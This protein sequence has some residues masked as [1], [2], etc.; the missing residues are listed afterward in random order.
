M[1]LVCCGEGRGDKSNRAERLLTSTSP[2]LREHADNPVDWYE[3]GPEALEKAKSENKPLIISIG[4]ASCHWCHVMEKESF[5]DTAVARLMNENFV[6]VKIDREQRPD[7]DQIYIHAAQLITGSAG[8]PLNAFA[9]PDGKPFYAGTYF[10]KDR[11]MSLLNQINDAYKTEKSAV[12]RQAEDVTRGITTEPLLSDSTDSV[13]SVTRAGYRSSFENWR[14]NFD[15]VFGGQRGAP[16]FPMPA[17]WESLLQL[18][19]LTDEPAALKIVKTTLDHMACGGIYDQLGGGFS[20]YTTDNAWKVPHFEKMLYDNA[21]LV[22]LY[23]H[24]F[25]LTKD[26][27]YKAVVIETLEFIKR[28]MTDNSGG[29]YSSLNAD[30]EG[31]EGRYYTWT[32]NEVEALLGEATSTLFCDYYQVTDSGNWEDGRNILIE[33]VRDVGF[34]SRVNMTEDEW[35]Q[36]KEAAKDKLFTA[37][38]QRTPPSTDTK[39]ITSWNALMLIAYLDA[40]AA[41]SDE[42]YLRSALAN[43]EFIINNMVTEGGGVLRNYSDGKKEIDGFLDDYANLSLAFIKLYQ[44]T[45]EIRWLEQAK[46]IVDFTV[47]NFRDAETGFFFYTSDLSE[48]LVARKKEMSDGDMP[49]SNSVMAEVLLLLGEFYQDPAYRLLAETMLNQVAAMYG[50]SSGVFYSNWARVSAVAAWRPFEVA[51]LGDDALA[52]NHDMQK[53]YNPLALFSGGRRENLPLLENKLVEGKTIIYVCRD[54]VCKIPVEDVQQA[55]KQLKAGE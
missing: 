21:Q 3:W 20:R 49:S 18:H 35:V 30:S 47:E 45:F 23:S 34:A 17:I 6:S 31:E 22:S 12:I 42:N 24:A 39:V 25:Q 44:H 26:P 16:K 9:L 54:R 32:R 50:G 8:W 33:H 43:A 27:M 29:F 5:M 15:D 51:I 41:T 11:W 48:D 37:R 53:H 13:F 36:M 40:Y 55:L 7:I 2:Y 1:L 4:Y 28:E 52:K 46:S 19:V 14:G 10:P 38:M